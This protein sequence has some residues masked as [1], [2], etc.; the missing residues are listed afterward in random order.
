MSD[1]LQSAAL[2]VTV[3]GLVSA[4]LVLARA[5]DGRLTLKVLLEFLVAAGLLRLTGDPSWRTIVT[6]AVVIAVRKL[7]TYELAR[8]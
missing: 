1:V 6:A 8:H 2:L 4:A 3:L 5:R 7:V